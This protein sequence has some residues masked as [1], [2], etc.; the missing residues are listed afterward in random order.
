MN[1]RKTFDTLIKAIKDGV[2]VEVRQDV[3]KSEYE[4]DRLFIGGVEYP[5][6]KNTFH[7]E[8]EPSGEWHGDN[9]D[10]TADFHIREAE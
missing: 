3:S 9:E 7:Y 8:V 2:L 6:E 5:I 4:R 10:I 1:L